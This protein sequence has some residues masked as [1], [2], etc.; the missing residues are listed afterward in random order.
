MPSDYDDVPYQI[1]QALQQQQQQQQQQSPAFSIVTD[2]SP[3]TQVMTRPNAEAHAESAI[4]QGFHLQFATAASLP[5]GLRLQQMLQVQAPEEFLHMLRSD[6]TNAL[7]ALSSLEDVQR[8]LDD[9]SS[10][11]QFRT[12]RLAACV[13]SIIGEADATRQHLGA[14]GQ[15]MQ[16]TETLWKRAD[17]QFKELMTRM[18][19]LEAAVKYESRSQA[20]FEADMSTKMNMLAQAVKD[21]QA[22]WARVD[23]SERAHTERAKA[24]SQEVAGVHA[25]LD[26]AGHVALTTDQRERL[27]ALCQAD[28]LTKSDGAQILQQM[29]DV[30]RDLD[31][32]M[33]HLESH[34]HA[35]ADRD[36]RLD[37]A[38]KGLEITTKLQRRCGELET[39]MAELM[40]HLG[41]DKAAQQFVPSRKTEQAQS[42]LI[43]H[44]GPV[45]HII[46]DPRCPT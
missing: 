8:R 3:Q 38:L 14:M 26:E 5:S 32:T 13:S 12:E 9:L 1:R 40:K 45:H 4:D 17:G 30:R 36:V 39:K 35:T 41:D 20:T 18:D 46:G 43:E 44:S 10:D 42:P 15:S 7:S 23:A 19:Q 16:D 34:V 37:G 6:R 27:D 31:K 21:L 29:Q 28:V 22:E 11:M 2:G 24:M 25:R 33:E